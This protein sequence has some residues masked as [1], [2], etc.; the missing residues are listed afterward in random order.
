MKAFDILVVY[1]VQTTTPKGKRR[2]R[3]VAQLCKNYG[4]RVQFSVFECRVSQA[5]LEVLEAHSLEILDT[6]KDSLRIYILH[7]GRE[8]SLRA[9]GVDRYRDFD[10]P[11]IL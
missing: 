5:Q 1:D 6:N 11:L 2:L 9:H 7:Q 4:Q 10:E 3:R 8:R